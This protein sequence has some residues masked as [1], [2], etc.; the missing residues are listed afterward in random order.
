MR[1][2]YDTAQ[3]DSSIDGLYGSNNCSA[4]Y[5]R[6]AR[7]SFT[8]FRLVWRWNVGRS[9]SRIV[10]NM[11]MTINLTKIC[12]AMNTSKNLDE[13]IQDFFAL[14]QKTQTSITDFDN[15]S[16][17][18]EDVFATINFEHFEHRLDRWYRAQREEMLMLINK[19][20]SPKI[21]LKGKKKRNS[22][23]SSET[24]H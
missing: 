18:R 7:I 19:F 23:I 15:L 12:D 21:K 3:D 11:I 4:Y 1:V 16:P 20:G 8:T 2:N 22:P 17:E 5:R 13:A 24:L 14:V 10:K 9:G 6:S